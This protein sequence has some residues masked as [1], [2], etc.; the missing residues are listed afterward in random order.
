MTESAQTFAASMHIPF[1]AEQLFGVF[2]AYHGAAWP[3]QIFLL[4]L[5]APTVIFIAIRCPCRP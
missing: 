3:A 5:A 1:T 2:Q 4:A